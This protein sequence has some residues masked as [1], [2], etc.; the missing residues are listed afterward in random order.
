MKNKK[1]IRFCCLK[2]EKRRISAS[3]ITRVA[4]L[5]QINR[6][7]TRISLRIAIIRRVW[8]CNFVDVWYTLSL[9][10]RGSHT[11]C[12]LRRVFISVRARRTRAHLESL[13]NACLVCEKKKSFHFWF[14]YC[15]S[16]SKLM[17]NFAICYY[18]QVIILLDFF[19]FFLV[20]CLFDGAIAVLKSEVFYLPGTRSC[21]RKKILNFSEILLPDAAVLS[22]KFRFIS[23]KIHVFTGAKFFSP[24][25]SRRTGSRE[26][27]RERDCH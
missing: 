3:G 14:N 2:K 27:E 9:I 8:R 13:R 20:V 17:T 16:Y 22:N 5:A 18:F 10:S 21:C 15:Y 1:T 12:L 19:C 24:R 25:T 23:R 26:R 6:C 11:S 7:A 4:W